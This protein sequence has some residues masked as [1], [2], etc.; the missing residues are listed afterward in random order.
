MEFDPIIE[1]LHKQ[2]KSCE[3][4][5]KDLRQQ[6]AE[7]ENLRSQ[8]RAQATELHRHSPYS[9]GDVLAHDMSLGIHD[10]FASEI[11][12]ALSHREERPK[13][14]ERRWPLDKAEYKRYGRQLI[15]PEIGL[16]GTYFFCSISSVLFLLYI[17]FCTSS[18]AHL[19]LYTFFCT[20][21][22]HLLL[23]VFF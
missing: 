3:N 20:S 18:S 12:A 21:S 22:A 14:I 2:I 19:L 15:M 17:S 11:T 4:Q 5:L 1:S 10:D 6:L 7:A 8:Q 23:Y 16:Q 13:E 9:A